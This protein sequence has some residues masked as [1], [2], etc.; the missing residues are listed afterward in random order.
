MTPSTFHTQLPLNVRVEGKHLVIEEVNWEGG[1]T[2]HRLSPTKPEYDHLIFP[3]FYGKL[4]FSIFEWCYHH[5]ISITL[6]GKDQSVLYHLT[7]PNRTFPKTKRLQATMTMKDAFPFLRALI[8]RKVSEQVSVL[9]R[10]ALAL[11]TISF[12]PLDDMKDK[13][14][15]R[16]TEASRQMIEIGVRL[17]HLRT[18][19]REILMGL[20]GQASRV[21]FDVLADLPIHWKRGKSY[22]LPSDLWATFG[23]RSGKNGNSPRGAIT[24][25][26]SLLNY[27]YT[28][29]ARRTSLALINAGLD[30]DLG[31]LHADHNQRENLVWDVLEPI[32]PTVDGWAIDIMLREQKPKDFIF[33]DDGTA[34]IKAHLLRDDINALEEMLWPKVRREATEVRT[35]LQRA[36]QSQE[37]EKTLRQ[38]A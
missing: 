5:G 6:L 1:K 34:V 26:H 33:T 20:E 19:D 4:S 2:I 28:I 24:P 23:P 14:G 17:R 25:F 12:N 38:D 18:V 32:R 8:V 7:P 3:A 15:E 37:D 30:P 9:D 22:R 36:S 29:L 35:F 27:G 10:L 21:Y 13:L 31:F 11:P 16:M